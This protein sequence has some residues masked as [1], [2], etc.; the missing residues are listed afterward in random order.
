MFLIAEKV[1]MTTQFMS[2]CGTTKPVWW[3]RTE[4]TSSF[5]VRFAL[6]GESVAAIGYFCWYG[7]FSIGVDQSLSLQDDVL[8][9]TLDWAYRM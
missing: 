3:G 9:I 8:H 4:G 1:S 7:Y 2:L 6:C 5:S